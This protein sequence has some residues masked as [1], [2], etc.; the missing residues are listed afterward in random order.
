MKK[1]SLKI[2]SFLTVL[3]ALAV[4]FV[5]VCRSQNLGSTVRVYTVPD[6]GQFSVDGQGYSHAAS[7]VWP[8]GSRHTLSIP[9]VVQAQT[10]TQFV[11]GSWNFSGG[12]IPGG[13]TIVIT[14]DPSVSAYYATFTEN[15]A[16]SLNYY[17]CPDPTHCSPPGLISVG[18]TIYNS[19]AD[20]Y[21]PANSSVVLVATPNDGFVFSGWAAGYGQS[22]AGTIDTVTLSQPITV[23]PRFQVARKINLQTVPAGLVV[24]ADRSQ[25][26]TPTTMQWGWDST[27]TVGPVSPQSDQ[28]GKFWIFSSWSDGGAAN[29]AYT[30]AEMTTPDTLTATYVPGVPVALQTAPSGLPLKVDGRSNWPSNNFLWGVGETHHLEAP[31]QQTDAQGR[32][33]SFGGWS[34]GG[35]AAQDLTITSS[36][37]GSGVSLT[38]TYNPVGHLTVNSTMSGLTIKVDGQ[39][40]ALPCD[41]QRPVGTSVSLSAPATLALASGSRGDFLGWPGS[42]STAGDWSV[43]LGPDPVNLS[44]N[45][46]TM[47]RLSSSAT[48]PDGATWSISPASADGFYDAQA[49]VTVGVSPLPGYRF[50]NWS[51]DLSGTKPIGIVAMTTPRAVQ[52]LLDRVPYI[53][54]AGVGNGAGTTPQSG[55]AA[56]SVVSVF[57]A[58]LS[59]DSVSGQANQ[60]AQTL[61]NVTVRAGD[62]F[63][64]IFFVSPTQINLQL[65]DDLQ[66][67][68]QTLTVSSSGMPD[69]QA[70]FTIVRN[71]PGL[72]TQ[73]L[74]GQTIA[75]AFHEDG[76]AVTVDAPA[77]NGELLT[78]YGTGFGPAD[79]QR[80]EGFPIPQAPPYLIVDSASVQVGDFTVNAESA[81]AVPGQIGIDAVQFRL[82]SG[83]PTATNAAL[84]IQIN[85]QSSNSV[86]LP[87]Q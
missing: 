53:A 47:N 32:I 72:F 87:V 2:G 44:L 7:F 46:R 62:R 42:G 83:A 6:G 29:H 8:A 12:S 60:L 50:R 58:N 66:P 68:A 24:L 41:V 86:F 78:V 63:M 52:A 77:L 36:M 51:G 76:S 48:P 18:G 21:M 3:L 31:A 4:V 25:V 54:P 73:T 74:N 56:G 10:K 65:P 38:A 34:N 81:F 49:T 39:D 79:H 37:V 75:L 30:V 22:I 69:V 26:P 33:Y 27:H 57:G 59:A 9:A 45:Y 82:G 16:L 71:A 28:Q 5:P 15:F 23:Y 35:A 19:D 55:V 13:G 84:Q 61:D 40:C 85:G 20:I 70:P 64:P 11:F 14:A 80:P 1:V 67:G 17:P 43:V